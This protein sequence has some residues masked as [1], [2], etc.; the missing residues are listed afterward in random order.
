[1]GIVSMIMA[2]ESMKQPADEVDEDDEAHDGPWRQRQPHDPVATS[3]GIR[4]T[5]RKCPNTMA[6][7][8][9]TR[10]MQLTRI[11]SS[12]DWTN[13]FQVRW[14]PTTAIRIVP[15]APMAAAS[16]GREEPDEDP[17]HHGDKEDERLDDACREAIFSR[18][19]KRGP[20]WQDRAGSMSR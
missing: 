13:P 14:R 1:M 11:V 4:V 8:T 6:P 12:S 10:I 16:V 7:A 9:M 2:S 15:T 17:A 3:K 18:R 20:G 19:V 5:A